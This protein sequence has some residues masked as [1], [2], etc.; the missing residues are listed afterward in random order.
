VPQGLPEI[1]ERIHDGCF[2]CDAAWRFTYL[3][4]AAERILGV[5]RDEVVGRTHW[6]VFPS[7]V[8]TT[9]EH[10]YRRAAA[11]ETGDFEF[12]SEP[13]GRWFHSRC[14]PMDGGGMVVYFEDITERKSTEDALREREKLYRELVEHVNSAI[15]RWSRDGS[16]TFVNERAQR[17]F[18]WTAEELLGQSV[19][20]LLPEGGAGGEDVSHLIDDILACPE[21]Y[22]NNVNVNAR[23]DGS[24]LWVAW[25][26]RVLVDEHGEAREVLVVGN[27]VTEL[28]A[29][30]AAQRESEERL[31]LALAGGAIATWDYQIESDK[32]AWNDQHYRML[33][34]VVG[35]VE[36]SF[37]S[38]HARVHPEDA[39]R[40]ADAFFGSLERGGDYRAGFRVLW[41][42]GTV[43]WIDAYGHLVTN[44][45]GAPQRSYGV[46]LDVTEKKHADRLDLERSTER[47]AQVE[48][49]RLARDLQDSVTHALFAAS[50][51]AEALMLSSDTFSPETARTIEE[52]RR[53]SR[54]AL[55]QMRTMLLELRSEPLE[56]VPLRQLLRNLVEAA[57]SRTSINVGLAVRGEGQPPAP[58]HVALYRIVEEALNNVARHSKATRAWVELDLAPESARLIVGDDGHGFDPAQADPSH[59]GLR[60]MRERAEEVGAEFT[61]VTHADEG[62]A[63]VVVWQRASSATA[64][65]R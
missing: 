39:Q 41:P 58:V 34:Y 52:L 65:F 11:G 30:Q 31:T 59:L 36:P 19:T 49:S 7:M 1:M 25:T 4:A 50:L 28:M 20:L 22:V 64:G 6:E 45:A 13:S 40:V 47:A 55:A 54:G 35:E 60:S 16:I 48:R 2:A 17:L 61:V 63:I 44:A 26:N 10:E 21:R 18:G 29:A 42:D 27:D 5:R 37:E 53:L 62:T 24:L 12:C 46:M 51:K 56:E 43:R 3:N 15:I 8:G 9:L 33:G 14:F 32:V 57:E 23:K 38:F